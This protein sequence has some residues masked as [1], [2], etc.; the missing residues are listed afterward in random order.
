M[1]E[2]KNDVHDENQGGPIADI[3]DLKRKEKERKKAGAAWSGARGAGPGFK[4]ATGGVG[5]GAGLSADGGVGIGAGLWGNLARMLAGASSTLLG[6]AALLVVALLVSAGAGMLGRSLLGGSN[7]GLGAPNLGGI[8]DSMRVRGPRGNRLGVASNGEVRF[9]P[10]KPDAGQSTAVNDAA[11]TPV[12]AEPAVPA[13]VPEA[14]PTKS[15]SPFGEKMGGGNWGP[16]NSLAHNLSGAKLSGSLGGQFGGKNIFSGSGDAKP[17]FS[18]GLAKVNPAKV[19]NNKGTLSGI[20]TKRPS[21][22]AAARTTSQARSSRALGQLKLAKGMSMLGVQAGTAEG[23]S[24]SAA[25][26]FDQQ[27]TSGG[28]MIGPT[29]PGEKVAP[30]SNTGA[31]DLTMP[32]APDAPTGGALDPGLQNSLGQI[33][34]MAD[35]A[36]QMQQQGTT[37][38]LLGAALIALG[39]YMLHA[40]WA[41]FG[42]TAAIGAMLIALG[43]VFVGMGNSMK[44]S[45]K[46]MADMAKASG[47][48]LSAQIGNQQQGKVIN[49]CTDQALAGTAVKDCTNSQDITHSDEIDAREQ[50]DAQKVRDMSKTNPVFDP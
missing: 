31:P 38:L 8:S 15:G 43:A 36:R 11:K 4:G 24:R 26:A 50:S 7:A 2:N 45:A 47:A 34:N 42:I 5:A 25:A 49:N 14:L 13:A 29:M 37:M 33:G 21:Y 17:R 28:E 1:P 32:T 18:Q 6:K 48:A 27:K 35:Q 20:A 16:Q 9:D 22:M 23:A 46:S 3:P 10:L 12:V 44:N 19:G 41:S 30:V 40:G 39:I